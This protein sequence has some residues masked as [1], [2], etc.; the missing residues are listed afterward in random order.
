M[1]EPGPG[2][3]VEGALSIQRLMPSNIALGRGRYQTVVQAIRTLVDISAFHSRIARFAA[4]EA[5]IGV[6]ARG[7]G[8]H[9]TG[10][11]EPASVSAAHVIRLLKIVRDAASTRLHACATSMCIA[12]PETV[13]LGTLRTL[14]IPRKVALTSLACS[15]TLPSPTGIPQ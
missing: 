3:L 1:G 12:R 4:A 8:L 9:T 11:T 5:S 15:R 13:R 14:C 2:A 10:T 6:G 7:V